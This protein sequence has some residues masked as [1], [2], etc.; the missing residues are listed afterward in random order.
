[1]LDLDLYIEYISKPRKL[2][3]DHACCTAPTGQI[4]ARPYLV[5]LFSERSRS[6]KMIDDLPKVRN[7]VV[8]IGGGAKS[9]NQIPLP[10]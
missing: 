7:S 2:V 4:G 10:M 8:N 9:I 6:S 3:L 5:Q 1:M